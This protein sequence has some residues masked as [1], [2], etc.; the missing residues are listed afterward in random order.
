MSGP[1]TG[2][3]ISKV[4]RPS[5]QR[6]LTSTSSWPLRNFT[7]MAS[8]SIFRVLDHPWLGVTQDS[9]SALPEHVAPIDPPRVVV[10]PGTPFAGPEVSPEVAGGGAPPAGGLAGV[11]GL[12]VLV[13]AGVVG[14]ALAATLDGVTVAGALVAAG[15]VIARGGGSDPS[16]EAASPARAM[17]SQPSVDTAPTTRSHRSMPVR[18]DRPSPPV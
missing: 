18:T 3:S 2:Q 7:S 5:L 9:A 8:F 13:A 1:T 4:G 17:A 12:P 11:L 10:D 6:T 15:A 16:S 14:G